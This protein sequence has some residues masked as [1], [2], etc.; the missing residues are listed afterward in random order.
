MN[1]TLLPFAAIECYFPVVMDEEVN[2]VKV[3]KV[4]KKSID[5]VSKVKS[6]ECLHQCSKMFAEPS[7]VESKVTKVTKVAKVTKVTK[8]KAFESLRQCSKMFTEPSVVESKVSHK[9]VYTCSACGGKGH[10]TR[11]CTSA[12]VPCAEPISLCFAGISAKKACSLSKVMDGQ[13]A[14]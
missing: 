2:V 1:N 5:N 9:K 10:N 8:V 3:V 11:K 12:C 6:F 14:Y 7:V 13:P 4:V